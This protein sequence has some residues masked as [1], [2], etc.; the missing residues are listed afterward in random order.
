MR[1]QLLITLAVMLI[2]YS[3]QL[4]AQTPQVSVADSINNRL[5]QLID[6]SNSFKQYKV[7]KTTSIQALRR[8]IHSEV[9]TLEQKIDDVHQELNKQNAKLEGVQATLKNTED[10]LEKA[11]ASKDQLALFGIT[12]QKGTYNS[13]VM[14][15]IVLLALALAVFI[16]KY[17]QSNSITQ[18]ASERLKKNEDEFSDYKKQA[19]ETQQ[20]LGRQIVD[21]RRKMSRTGTQG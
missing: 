15:I 14:G 5:T 6:D 13:I 2:S 21:E 12:V 8:N 16:H 20:R 19:L 11:I 3:Q 18:E 7:I 17:R 9:A 10:N 1:K 4:T